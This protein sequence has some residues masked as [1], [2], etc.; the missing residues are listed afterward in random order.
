M[1]GYHE[2]FRQIAFRDTLPDDA[3]V[4]FIKLVPT[5]VLFFVQNWI[6]T[7]RG[8]L[9]SSALVDVLVWNFQCHGRGENQ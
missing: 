3:S 5:S 1:L 8:S 9:R 7:R 6:S 4:A 2:G